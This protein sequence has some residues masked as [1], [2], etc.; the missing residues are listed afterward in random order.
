MLLVSPDR[1][2]HLHILPQATCRV[3]RLDYISRFISFLSLLPSSGLSTVLRDPEPQVVPAGGTARFECHIDGVPAPRITWEKNH[4]PLPVPA[5]SVTTPRWDSSVW[6]MI[7]QQMCILQTS[8][9][10]RWVYYVLKC[11]VALRIAERRFHFM[12]VSFQ[13]FILCEIR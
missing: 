4:M 9:C 6:I 10:C 2:L 11:S 3:Y 13:S 1:R 8:A 5:E 12:F 7:K